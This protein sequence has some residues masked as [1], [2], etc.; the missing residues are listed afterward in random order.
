MIT[1]QLQVDLCNQ[2]LRALGEKPIA[3]PYDETNPRWLLAQEFYD[4]VQDE[5]LTQHHWN[6]A[7]A[8]PEDYLAM[9]RV[10]TFT[11]YQREGAYFLADET[12]LPLT[13]TT[14]VE[15]VSLWPPFFKS[16]FIAALTAAMAEQITGQQAKHQ[17]WM[18]IAAT[19]L[20][21]ATA[22]DGQEGTPP[23]LQ[24]PDLIVARRTGSRAGW[25]WR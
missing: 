15:D 6:F 14:R 4:Q 25:G 2:A 10:Q 8:V 20:R 13:Y 16:F 19:R 22:L 3:L 23:A 18:Q 21:R 9:Q 1:T 17:L 24:S 11:R 12:T 5:A 7:F